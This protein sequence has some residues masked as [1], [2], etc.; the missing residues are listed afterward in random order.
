MSF[1]CPVKRLKKVVTSADGIHEVPRDSRLPARGSEHAAGWDV[2]ACIDE[3]AAIIVP[4]WGRAKIPTG[5][6][7]AIPVGYEMQIRP[8]SGH[9]L[10]FG[11]TVINAPGTLDADYRG[12]LFVALANMSG[13]PFVVQ[14]HDRIAQLVFAKHETPEFQEVEDLEETVRGEGGFGST[15]K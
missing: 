13:T 14:H 15:G 11:V 8:R 5:L 6:A 2:Y 3:N 12:E 10:K 1:P 7:F 9:A 4:P